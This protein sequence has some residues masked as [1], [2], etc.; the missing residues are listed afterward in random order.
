VARCGCQSAAG[1]IG[2][3]DTQ[4]VD[5]SLI[6][7]ILTATARI[8][9]A[10]GNIL[11]LAANGLRVD[12]NAVAECVG[13]AAAVTVQDSPG[14]AF[15]E[16]GAGT[17]DDPRVISG[18]V[19]A[20][21]LQTSAATWTHTIA[22]ASGTWEKITE[23]PNLTATVPGLYWVT[24]DAVANVTIPANA[25][26]SNSAAAASIYLAKNDGMVPNTETRVNLESQSNPTTAQPALQLHGTGSVSRMV[27]LAAGDY[28]SLWT[29]RAST[30][31]AT[32]EILSNNVGRT[33]ITAHR[34]GA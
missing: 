32:T 26:G 13:G 4:S 31:S 28:L 18:D 10:A 30:A 9:P 6:N 1:A 29:Q 24:A 8:D 19:K 14:I 21:F 33:R 11:Q 3:A 2:V 23:L 25:G 12:C 22:A 34:I 27:Q 7:Q 16:S 5:L 20:V 17:A 15:T